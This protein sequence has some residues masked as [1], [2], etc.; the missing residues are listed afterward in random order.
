M[1]C[2]SSPSA[3][4]VGRRDSTRVDVEMPTPGT[5]RE[6]ELGQESLLGKAAL[7]TQKPRPASCQEATWGPRQGPAALPLDPPPRVV[8]LQGKGQRP[9][10]LLLSEA[11]QVGQKAHWLPPGPCCLWRW[12]LGAGAT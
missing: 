5:H 8:L 9:P 1:G 7:N 10:G 4:A 2:V 6:L 3:Q 11:P 12:G